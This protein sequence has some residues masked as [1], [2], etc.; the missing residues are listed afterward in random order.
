MRSARAAKT[1]RAAS[2]SRCVPRCGARCCDAA[3]EYRLKIEGEL[4]AV[5]SEDIAL[6]DA[7][8]L[9]N[10]KAADTRIFYYKMKGDYHRY[11]AE[12]SAGESAASAGALAAYQA[13]SAIAG[14][15]L[16]PSNPIRLGLALNFSVFYFEIL[17]Q[18]AQACQLAKAAFD[19]ALGEIDNLPADAYKDSTM[20]LQLLRDN[21]TLWETTDGACAG[22]SVAPCSPRGRRA[23]RVAVCACGPMHG[24]G[25]ASRANAVTSSLILSMSIPRWLS[26]PC[27]RHQRR[28]RAAHVPSG[29]R[30]TGRTAAGT[31]RPWCRPADTCACTSC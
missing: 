1:T 13:A 4:A 3:Q 11:V 22:G 23:G 7:A 19:D 29:R 10:A 15:E 9:P 17:S 27:C 24:Y 2:S 30:G 31:R 21:L 25:L 5:S 26:A 8:L 16:L 28:H 12:F 20:I 18:P 14:A 6:I